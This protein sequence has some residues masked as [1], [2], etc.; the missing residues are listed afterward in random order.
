MPFIVPVSVRRY[1]P[2][3][4]YRTRILE[5]KNSFAV[6][7]R[8]AEVLLTC[9]VPLSTIAIRKLLPRVHRSTGSAA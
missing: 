5:L 1:I 6:T 7:V 8:R 9:I 2:A 4:V 3:A